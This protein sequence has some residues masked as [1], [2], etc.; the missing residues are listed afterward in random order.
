M[1]GPLAHLPTAGKC[2]HP[3][4]QTRKRVGVVLNLDRHPITFECPKCHFLNSVTLGS[5]RLGKRVIC[6]GCKTNI[7]LS[8]PWQTTKR[9]QKQIDE[10][11]KE[12]QQTLSLNIKIG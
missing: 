6:R 4:S 2:G 1:V 7:Q 9:A 5:V 10:S 8:D 12:L 3:T 11:L